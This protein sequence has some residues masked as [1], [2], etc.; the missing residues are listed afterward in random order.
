M[1]I[2]S[3][4]TTFERGVHRV[5]ADVDG[6]PLWF[7]SADVALSPSPEAFASAMLIP[8]I[9]RGEKLTL[10]DALSPIWLS[11][12]KQILTAF[13]EW[14]DYAKI[15]PESAAASSTVI[16]SEIPR[17]TKTALCFTGGVDSF[18]TLLRSG[19]E[20]NYLVY[21]IGYDMRLDDVRRFAAFEPS[22]RAAA[23]AAGA[24]PVVIRTNLRELSSFSP[25]SWERTHG[26]ALAAI[27]HLLGG[28]AG[29]LLISS[30]IPYNGDRV[31]GSHWRTDQFWSSERLS[32]INV[33]SEA[34]RNVKLKSIAG[35]ALV[36]EHLRVCWENREAAGNCS[37]CEKCVRTR[38]LLAGCGELDNYPGFKNGD[39]LLDDVN[40]LPHSHSI[41]NSYLQ[42]ARAPRLGWRLRLA[43]WRLLARTKI[44]EALNRE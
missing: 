6:T 42:A 31:W 12:V 10:E 14:W 23:A 44:F 32:V 11:N 37:R 41:I 27:G 17:A 16:P 30:S 21:V 25:V 24:A 2:S 35:E 18:Y 1:R 33:G 19:Y 13:N 9:V 34:W 8:A 29:Q 22:L 3:L 7:E 40:A 28:V 39:S 15:P 26:G 4:T 20:I 43:A 38:L 36:R 5:I